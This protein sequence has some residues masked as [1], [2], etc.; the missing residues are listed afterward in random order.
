M[1]LPMHVWSSTSCA[2]RI[3]AS[4]IVN[5]ASRASCGPLT[6]N[7]WHDE[8]GSGNGS[9]LKFNEVPDLVTGG[10]QPY[11]AIPLPL[12]SAFVV[13]SSKRRDGRFIS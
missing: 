1:L 3:T 10:I 5:G 13:K 12:Q 9:A 6:S 7:G 2:V 4:A 11:G 8:T